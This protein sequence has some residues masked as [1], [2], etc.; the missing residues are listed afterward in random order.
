MVISL[1][2]G[3]QLHSP[4]L[5]ILFQPSSS[6]PR[7]DPSNPFREF[8]I[9]SLFHVR[10]KRE[11]TFHNEIAFHRIRTWL[12][13]KIKSFMKRLWIYTEERWE[14]TESVM[15]VGFSLDHRQQPHL[16]PPNG[17][18]DPLVFVV[19]LSY[20]PTSWDETML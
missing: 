15:Q 5:L 16:L 13:V 20:L 9:L 18:W 19:L 1:Y 4:S 17:F 8:L 11:N 14:K 7:M 12:F 10:K 2:N 6:F 3:Y